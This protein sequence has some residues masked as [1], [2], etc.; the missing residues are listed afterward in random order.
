MIIDTIIIIS[1]I[2]ST[3]RSL[4]CSLNPIC[5]YKTCIWGSHTRFA[6]NITGLACLRF[7]NRE[8][9]WEF[10]AGFLTLGHTFFPHNSN[11]FTSYR[12]SWRITTSKARTRWSKTSWTFKI[13]NSTVSFLI[14]KNP[15]SLHSHKTPVLVEVFEFLQVS[16]ADESEQVAHPN[17][18]Y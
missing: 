1:S 6:L 17:G 2:T 14:L 16:H 3:Q 7:P 12:V 13:T 15:S 5:T 10:D 18:H 9:S 11:T 4:H 8:S